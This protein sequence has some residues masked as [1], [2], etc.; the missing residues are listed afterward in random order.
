MTQAKPN[1]V[2]YWVVD[3][4]DVGTC[5]KCGEVRDFVEIRA[6][7]RLHRVVHRVAPVRHGKVN[8]KR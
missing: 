7:E 5:I 8:H 1:C 3:R 6:R 4:H 2:H